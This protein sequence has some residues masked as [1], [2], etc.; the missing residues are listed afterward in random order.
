M[1]TRGMRRAARTLDRAKGKLAA[2]QFAAALSGLEVLLRTTAARH[3]RFAARLRQRDLVA[4]IRLADGSIARAYSIRDGRV[5][6]RS[7]LHPSPDLTM[8]FDSAEVANR[9]MRPDRDYLEFIDALKNFQMHVEGPDDLAVWFSE[10]LQSLLSAG[11]E[12]GT[13]A[14]EGVRRYT[15]NTN[16][17]PG[18]RLRAR[19]A[20][21]CASRQSSSTRMMRS[22][23]PS[24]HAARRS[25]R[26]ARP[27]S[28]RTRWPGSR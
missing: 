4:L 22:R 6:S 13:D 28:V 15:S 16:G 8:T 19:T 18:L 5:R 3:P 12:F 10:T 14:G 26:R 24:T 7:G 1:A 27:P 17:G 23:G 25:R 11:L 21:S 20:G 2:I 9:V